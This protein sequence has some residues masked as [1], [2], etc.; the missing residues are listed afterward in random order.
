MKNGLLLRFDKNQPSKATFE[1]HRTKAETYVLETE[2]EKL[3]KKGVISPN[4][5]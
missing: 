1:F 4:K 3:L 2:V 5:I